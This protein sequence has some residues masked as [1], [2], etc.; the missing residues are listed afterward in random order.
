M[1]RSN[2]KVN[3]VLIY[4]LII[5]HKGEKD[6][7]LP[8]KTAPMTDLEQCLDHRLM[9]FRTGPLISVELCQLW[10]STDQ[11]FCVWSNN[12]HV[13]TVKAM[14]WQFPFLQKRSKDVMKH[15]YAFLG[16]CTNFFPLNVWK[17]QERSYVKIPLLLQWM[18]DLLKLTVKQVLTT[19]GFQ[20][21]FKHWIDSQ[22]YTF[23][24][25]NKIVIGNCIFVP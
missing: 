4:N 2:G 3:K 6:G 22:L 17:M 8:F 15:C 10:L 1:W 24:F 23:T 11:P 13:L 25:I 14:L 21:K 19:V 9:Q 7:S 16:Y 18:K 20:Y 5:W 12:M